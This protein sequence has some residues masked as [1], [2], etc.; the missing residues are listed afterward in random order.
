MV[1]AGC[2]GGTPI[3][4]NDPALRAVGLGRRSA[5]PSKPCKEAAG[6]STDIQDH[7]SQP[8]AGASATIAAGDF[9]FAPT[10]AA[11]AAS[12]TIT[13]TVHNGG[14][15][16]HNVT[17]ADQ[18]IDQDVEAG[19]TITVQLKLDGAPVQYFCKYHRTSGMVGA[20]LPAGT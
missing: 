17:I 7:G 10:C 15:A 6:F 16:L 9:F 14:Q 11:Q 18:N 4:P 5:A 19:Q 20:V 12:G 1:A 3:G 2:S 13:L 8:V